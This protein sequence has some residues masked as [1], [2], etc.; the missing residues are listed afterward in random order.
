MG[1]TSTKDCFATFS[2]TFHQK[3]NHHNCF[4]FRNGEILTAFRQYDLASA[5][6]YWSTYLCPLVFLEVLLGRLKGRPCHGGVLLHHHHCNRNPISDGCSTVLTAFNTV[7]EFVDIL[8]EFDNQNSETNPNSKLFNSLVMIQACLI[9]P[10]LDSYH[11]QKV[12][13]ASFF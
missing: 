4:F 11:T 3:G 9:F 5:K 10:S 2:S 6:Q 1:S 12:N 13:F 8:G 7:S